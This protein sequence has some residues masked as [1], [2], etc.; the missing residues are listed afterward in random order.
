MISNLRERVLLAIKS[1]D[2]CL[3]TYKVI[4]HGLHNILSLTCEICPIAVTVD[5]VRSSEMVCP[6]K[7]RVSPNYAYEVYD[8]R[9]RLLIDWYHREYGAEDIV[10]ALL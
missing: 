4:E 3:A 8:E 1:S 10:E 5:N 6:V 9:R 2:V 7:L